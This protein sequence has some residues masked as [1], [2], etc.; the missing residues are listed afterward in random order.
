MNK[1][2]LII[3]V[4]ATGSLTGYADYIDFLKKG[5]FANLSFSATEYSVTFNGKK[6]SYIVLL[7]NE[8]GTDDFSRR[9][10]KPNE[11]I[12][13]PA[14]T[15]LRLVLADSCYTFYSWENVPPT[16]LK[17]LI[18][19]KPLVP[20]AYFLFTRCY[21]PGGKDLNMKEFIFLTA[22]VSESDKNRLIDILRSSPDFFVSVK[23]GMIIATSL[24]C[25]KFI[26]D[27]DKI[28]TANKGSNK[29]ISKEVAAA[30][31][32]YR[33]KVAEDNR[34]SAE[35]AQKE[36]EIRV[37]ERWK[38]AERKHKLFLQ[39]ERGK[40]FKEK[41]FISLQIEVKKK[42]L[43]FLASQNSR[44]DYNACVTAVE[45]LYTADNSH[46]DNT[47]M[48][49][50]QVNWLLGRYDE[51][52]NG[53]N[54]IIA[55]SS[56]SHKRMIPQL[57]LAEALQENHQDKK[58]E[59]VYRDIIKQQNAIS[60]TVRWRE[61]TLAYFHL[62]EF[63]VQNKN[64][65]SAI[66]YLNKI[67]AIPVLDDQRE[68]MILFHS[69]AKFNISVLKNGLEATSQKMQGDH[70]HKISYSVL[71]NGLALGDNGR[72]QGGLIR[73]NKPHDN[74]ML[75]F[76]H[77]LETTL[78]K[79][80]SET[81]RVLAA[82]L[83]GHAYFMRQDYENAARYFN[84]VFQGKSFFAPDAGLWLIDCRD[85]QEKTKKKRVRT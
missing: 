33:E 59:S 50:V 69:W 17:D 61:I 45:T 34:I 81:D 27:M 66:D 79:S 85:K 29:T 2:V 41:Q 26:D 62:A 25:K 46:D 42:L 31:A 72:I 48:I 44:D 56:E 40:S 49:Y 60:Q 64:P 8:T 73:F 20:H 36:Y 39:K 18:K 68:A 82:L 63:A 53:L 67:L 47:L 5:T 21:R 19:A 3:L 24:N 14:K 58:A 43:F 15:K 51:A 38:E 11:K 35:R 12:T 57:W 6:V 65:D 77:A 30:N 32:K 28:F 13:L 7:D 74:S 83:L 4:Y 78:A 70:F 80:S 84:I 23:D 10:S 76:F 54:Q 55:A 22:G 37:A 52:I 71:R 75:M 9:Y 16:E 1:W